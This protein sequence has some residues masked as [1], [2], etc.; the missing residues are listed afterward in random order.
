[1]PSSR[2]FFLIDGC[3][4]VG[5]FTFGIK[6]VTKKNKMLTKRCETGLK[7]MTEEDWLIIAED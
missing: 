3:I 2:V 6:P 1:M 7:I 4:P 5:D